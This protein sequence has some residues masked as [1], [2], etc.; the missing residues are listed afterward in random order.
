MHFSIG[1]H[2]VINSAL[3]PLTTQYRKIN[4]VICINRFIAYK[5]YNSTR[6]TPIYLTWGDKWTRKQYKLLSIYEYPTILNQP[7]ALDWSRPTGNPLQHQSRAQR[8]SASEVVS[9]MHSHSVTFSPRL[10][11]PFLILAFCKKN[12]IFFRVPILVSACKPRCRL[13]VVP[14][15]PRPTCT[16][17]DRLPTETTVMPRWIRMVPTPRR[18]QKATAI[19]ALS[20]LR[21]SC[22]HPQS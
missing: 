6:L 9:L 18:R 10:C 8:V 16:L 3:S 15:C 13:A 4:Y 19:N 7:H 2:S 20:E 12:A 1:S 5:V 14:L 17:L 22:P 11:V 21:F